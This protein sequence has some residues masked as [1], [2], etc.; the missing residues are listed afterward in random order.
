[1][2]TIL[3]PVPVHILDLSVPSRSLIEAYMAADKN[4]LT[5][6]FPLHRPWPVCRLGSNH[7]PKDDDPELHSTPNIQSQQPLQ[8]NLST[9]TTSSR[10]LDSLHRVPGDAVRTLCA[11]RRHPLKEVLESGNRQ[12]V[13]LRP[14]FESEHLTSLS[15]T[16]QPTNTISS[17]TTFRVNPSLPYIRFPVMSDLVLGYHTSYLQAFRSVRDTIQVF[18]GLP[19]W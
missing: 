5:G 17:S 9:P 16:R 18:L 19:V 6:F 13:T 1:M 10:C 4:A 3:P 12:S 15:R 7:E 14:L 8:I 11:L 2:C